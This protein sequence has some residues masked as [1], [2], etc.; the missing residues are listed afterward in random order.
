MSQHLSRP[1]AKCSCTCQS[2]IIQRPRIT[3]NSASPALISCSFPNRTQSVISR[4]I[5]STTAREPLR[6]I[7]EDLDCPGNMGVIVARSAKAS[8]AAYFVRRHRACSSSNGARS[9]KSMKAARRRS[10]VFADPD[11]IERTVRDLF[12]R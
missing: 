1:G 10:A 3:T 2:P 5:E 11:L 4:K 7:F 6:K 8:G 12:D 9:N